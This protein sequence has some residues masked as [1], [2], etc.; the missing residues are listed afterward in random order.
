M[1]NVCSFRTVAAMRIL[2]FVNLSE[3]Y[4]KDET[5]YGIASPSYVYPYDY[6]QEQR[7]TV[8]SFFN[9]RVFQE[10]RQNLTRREERPNM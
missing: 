3:T 10:L 7:Q 2:V 1:P 4:R 6:H 5:K 8:L 9:T